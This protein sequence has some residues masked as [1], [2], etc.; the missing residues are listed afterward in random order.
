[1]RVLFIQCHLASPVGERTGGR[2]RR[3]RIF[4]WRH[5]VLELRLRAYVPRLR[6]ARCRL[7]HAPLEHGKIPMRRSIRLI[8][9][10]T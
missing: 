7:L 3:A 1:M 9:H 6:L 10:R 4:G 5:L 2:T 8:H